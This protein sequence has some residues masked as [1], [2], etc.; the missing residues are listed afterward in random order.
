[1]FD[2]YK[3]YMQKDKWRVMDNNFE[4]LND[5]LVRSDYDIYSCEGRNETYPQLI[6][7]LNLSEKSE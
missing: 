1:M 5:I 6:L 3:L 4:Y 7:E 2:H